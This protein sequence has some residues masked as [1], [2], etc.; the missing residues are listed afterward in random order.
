MYN[1]KIM[2]C[3]IFLDIQLIVAV[4]ISRWITWDRMP[5]AWARKKLENLKNRDHYEYLSVNEG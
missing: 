4:D 3:R 5:H 2:F 1:K